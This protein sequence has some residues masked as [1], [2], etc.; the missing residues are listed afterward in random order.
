MAESKVS[1][2]LMSYIG[3]MIVAKTYHNR[4]SARASNPRRYCF[5]VITKSNIINCLF[6]RLTERIVYCCVFQHWAGSH[7]VMSKASDSFAKWVS[8]S[9]VV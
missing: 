2:C 7:M 6:T 3:N 5:L 9:K 8:S 4:L 1:L